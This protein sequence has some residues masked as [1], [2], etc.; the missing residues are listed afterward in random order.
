MEKTLYL[1][2]ENGKIFKGFS[3]GYEGEAIGETVFQTAVLG[4]NEALCDQAYCGQLLVQTF[5][6][7][8]NYGIIPQELDNKCPVLGGYIVKSICDSPSNFRC[9]GSLE[10]YL[11]EKKI[12]GLAGIDTRELTKI[13]RDEGTLNGKITSDISDVDA[14]LKELKSYKASICLCKTSTDKPYTINAENSTAKVC[15]LDFGASGD[16]VNNLVSMGISVEVLPYNT[17]AIDIISFNP[18]G[19]VLSQGPGNPNDYEDVITELKEILKNK[20]P[21]YACGLG[22]ELVALALGAKVDKLKF[23]H[24][25]CNQPV[26]DVIS[27]KIYISSQN[28]G[29]A[30]DAASLPEGAQVTYINVND[31]TV[32]GF[33]APGVIS[34]QFAPNLCKGP[35]NT[36]HIFNEFKNIM[37]GDR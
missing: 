16:F 1:V 32:E 6:L 3:I 10:D 25:G 22:H 17:K 36:E 30:V 34:T 15:M 7:I 27:G 23:G 20:I 35:H 9:N 11:K 8:G 33:K 28:H 29:Y 4:Y 13:I 12:V 26:K 24:R 21:V 37:K 18:Q 19:V 14:I 31:K 5:P 2:L